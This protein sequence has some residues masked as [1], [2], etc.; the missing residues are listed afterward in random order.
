MS[1]ILDQQEF[2][3]LMQLYRIADMS[4]QEVVTR[5]FEAVKQHIRENLG[6]IDDTDPSGNEQC[7][8][9]TYIHS[10]SYCINCNENYSEYVEVL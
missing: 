10:K 6:D 5:R 8:T 1:D 9:C 7:E 3:D 2:Y 4:N